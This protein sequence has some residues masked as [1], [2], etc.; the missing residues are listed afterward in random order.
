MLKTFKCSP[1][2][3]KLISPSRN[4]PISQTISRRRITQLNNSWT[5]FLFFS[6]LENNFYPSWIIC[7]HFFFKGLL[8]FW[9]VIL[10]VEC[11]RS[12]C[13]SISSY[14]YAIHLFCRKFFFLTLVHVLGMKR[15]L[16]FCVIRQ[17]C[18]LNDFSHCGGFIHFY[19][20]DRIFHPQEGS[21]H[22]VDLTEFFT[23]IGSVHLFWIG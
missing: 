21:V 2:W 22:F 16:P 13:F 3:M 23:F 7:K 17:L 1:R 19:G 15:L 12:L 5:H 11:I 4:R 14:P 20:L 10:F 9:C 8:I 18:W 6:Y